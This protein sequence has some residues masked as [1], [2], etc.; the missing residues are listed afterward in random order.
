MKCLE[1][2]IL[3]L[4]VGF[5]AHLGLAPRHTRYR[6]K[7]GISLK[8]VVFL[9]AMFS[10]LLGDECGGGTLPEDE[11]T[12]V[13]HGASSTRPTGT[14]PGLG[15][16]SHHSFTLPA[17]DELPELHLDLSIAP[18]PANSADHSKKPLI[19]YIMDPDPVLFGSA[20]LFAFSQASY[21]AD[22]AEENEEV[23]FKH[24]WIVGIGHAG[25]E[26]DLTN[27]GFDTAKLRALRRRDFP[28]RDHPAVGPPGRQPNAHA[29]RLA[30]GIAQQV[31]PYVEANIISPGITPVVGRT[32]GCRRALL[33]ASYSAVLALQVLLRQPTTVHEFIL[34][35]PSVPFDPEIMKELEGTS[36]DVSAVKNNQA[37]ALILYGDREKLG[38][39]LVGNVHDGIP[40]AAE[41]LAAVLR[42]Q[43]LAVDGAH[44]IPGEDHSTVKFSLVSRGLMWFARRS[45]RIEAAQCASSVQSPNAPDAVA[46]NPIS[47]ESPEIPTRRGGTRR[48]SII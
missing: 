19:L 2:L 17:Q 31:I 48:E 16:V 42:H 34:G 39:R 8:P 35:S 46:A 43:G 26:Y 10:W 47:E 4:R 33:G 1:T 3:R 23:A 5:R 45:M 6:C 15:R 25:R 11:D 44:S 36:L 40:A 14:V 32:L 21:F 29:A 13:P 41:D 28:P 38:L 20:A 30:D 27:D 37:G 12:S 24:M 9:F 22:S 18:P 7:I